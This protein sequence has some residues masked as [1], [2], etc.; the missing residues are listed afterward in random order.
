MPLSRSAARLAALLLC[1]ALVAPVPARADTVDDAAKLYQ[2]GNEAAALERIDRY[3][4][5][6]PT[7][8]RGR[9]LKAQLLTAQGKTDEAIVLYNGIIEEFPELAE[10]YN[11]LAV[12]YAQQGRY[13]LALNYL[14][15]AVQA[16]PEYSV[17]LENLGDVHAKISEAS[18]RQAAKYDPGNSGLQAKIATLTKLIPDK[19]PTPVFRTPLPPKPG[20][21]AKKKKGSG[22]A[23]TPAQ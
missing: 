1:F 7:D 6:R 16:F 10:P 2:E 11:N 15:Q 23:P 4:L 9:F 5:D 14:Q 18:Y 8:V 19:A 3:L 12:I 22:T 17:A 20:A 13:E 21:G